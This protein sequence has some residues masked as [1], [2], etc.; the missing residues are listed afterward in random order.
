[1]KMSPI[2]I[3]QVQYVTEYSRHFYFFLCYIESVFT[4]KL[5]NLLKDKNLLTQECILN[6]ISLTNI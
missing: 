4:N 3:V 5:L 6:F 2:H 1:M